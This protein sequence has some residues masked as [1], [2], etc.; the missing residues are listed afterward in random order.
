MGMTKFGLSQHVSQE[1]AND[2]EQ[3]GD[4]RRNGCVESALANLKAGACRVP[5]HERHIGLQEKK[6]VS[7]QITRHGG[8]QDRHGP[9]CPCLTPMSDRRP[10]KN[11]LGSDVFD[12][13]AVRLHLTFLSYFHGSRTHS[14]SRL[15][16]GNACLQTGKLFGKG[17]SI[18]RTLWRAWKIGDYVNPLR[19]FKSA[20]PHAAIIFQFR[21]CRLHT[22]AQDD[23][24]L[25]DLSVH[26]VRLTK[27]CRLKYFRVR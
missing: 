6:S 8:D 21:F 11:L 22:W 12:C 15:L 26:C 2:E 9:L 13:G 7:I 19:H 14:L 20:E 27:R 16:A 18:N 3:D 10:S 23:C 4:S 24:R 1:T 5:A 17:M 25:H